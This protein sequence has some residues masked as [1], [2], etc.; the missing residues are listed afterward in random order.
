MLADETKPEPEGAES[1][2]TTPARVV[3][4][5]EARAWLRAN[6]AQPTDAVVTSLPDI[7]ELPELGPG[8]SGWQNWFVETAGELLCWTAPGMPCLFFQSDVRHHGRWIDKSYLV[9]KAAEQAGATLVFHKIVCRH[10]PGTLTQGRASYSHLLALVRGAELIPRK[11]SADVLP[12]A[13][14][15]SW[16]RA[17]GA[18]ACEA[19]CRFLLAETPAR[20]VVDPFCGKGSVLAIANALGLDAL[21][22]E[23]SAKRC[24]A[25]RKLTAAS[26]TDSSPP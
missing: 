19:A 3:V 24:R 26:L 7:S 11:P 17:M 21:G 23:L 5:A 14:A 22:V 12:D 16:S 25:A 2:G 6:P 18:R 10:A 15:M 9:Q 13:G 8:L 1:Q 20:R 4:Q